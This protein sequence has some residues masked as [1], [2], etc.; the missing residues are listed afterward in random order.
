MEERAFLWQIFDLMDIFKKN[1]SAI[2][3]CSRNTKM[4]GGIEWPN[5]PSTH[6]L[7]HCD[8]KIIEFLM[9]Y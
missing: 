4:E 3:F 5:G 7:R 8:S 2:V 9:I 1:A 6:Q